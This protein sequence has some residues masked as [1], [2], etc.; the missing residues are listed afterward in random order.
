[1]APKP[2]KISTVDITRDQITS[3]EYCNNSTHEY[4]TYITEFIEDKLNKN[5][6]LSEILLSRYFSKVCNSVECWSYNYK[7]LLQLTNR[8]YETVTITDTLIKKILVLYNAE[9]FVLYI[10]SLKNINTDKIS[11]LFE[12]IETIPYSETRID[13]NETL[14]NY[15]ISSKNQDILNLCFNIVINMNGDYNLI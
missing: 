9:V 15:C 2:Q 13:M 8:I 4:C 3:K 12:L 1:M 5:E 11:A 6:E 7:T 14:I 10:N